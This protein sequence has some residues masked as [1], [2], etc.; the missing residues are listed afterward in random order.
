MKKKNILLII[1][2]LIICLIICISTG[3]S[4]IPEDEAVALI[5]KQLS[6]KY[7]TDFKVTAIDLSD[8]T[9]TATV[10]KI[11]SFSFFTATYNPENGSLYDNYQETNPV[12]SVNGK[13]NDIIKKYDFIDE[14]DVEIQIVDSIM[15]YFDEMSYFDANRETM[16]S[17]LKK[18]FAQE[19]FLA[20]SLKDT[21]FYISGHLSVSE[22][23]P[24][25]ITEEFINLLDELSAENIYGN[26]D[27]TNA[28][29]NKSKDTRIDFGDSPIE[30]EEMKEI[31]SE[32]NLYSWREPYSP[33]T[34]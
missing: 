22:P 6:E 31:L 33:K 9:F 34:R 14:F 25:E 7:D 13:I 18:S 17:F 30:Q 21:G 10:T 1:F 27:I 26:F 24:T 5:E 3:C 11:N 2:S 19:D 4:N 15:N 32:L 12:K 20:D 28:V 23:Y 29:E 8:K 16:L